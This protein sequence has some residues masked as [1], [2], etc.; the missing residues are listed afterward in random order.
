MVW[1]CQKTGSNL[2]KTN[3]DLQ[4]EHHFGR[5]NQIGVN[6]FPSTFVGIYI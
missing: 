6:D 4:L 1:V 2:N 3:L 5:H